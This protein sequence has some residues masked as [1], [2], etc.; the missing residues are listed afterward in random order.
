MFPLADG[1]LILE[2]NGRSLVKVTEGPQDAFRSVAPAALGISNFVTKKMRPIVKRFD[3]GEDTE[4]DEISPD[5]YNRAQGGLPIALVPED[6]SVQIIPADPMYSQ[7]AQA[8]NELAR[9]CA[10]TW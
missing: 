7:W 8:Q 10:A 3:L 5:V 4:V 1:Q 6:L 2:R 9:P